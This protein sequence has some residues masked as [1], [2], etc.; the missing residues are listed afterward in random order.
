M[1]FCPKKA[2]KFCWENVLVAKKIEQMSVRFSM[3]QHVVIFVFN[4]VKLNMKHLVLQVIS[5]ELIDQ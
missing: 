1:Q 5:I 3:L 4:T 2:P